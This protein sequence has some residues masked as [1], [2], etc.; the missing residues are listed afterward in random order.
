MKWTE[1]VIKTNR[2]AYDA[3]AD[4]L[5]SI[6]S[7][8]VAIQDPNDIMQK[9]SYKELTSE[10]LLTD[11]VLSMDLSEQNPAGTIDEYIDEE[12]LNEIN[13]MGKD[14][15]IIK[16]YFPESTNSVELI[17]LINEKL[18]DI[19]R[20]L[21]TGSLK[22]E[23][24]EVQ[25]EDWS[26][27]WKKY[28]KPFNITE[29][30]IIKPTWES[31]DS[32]EEK[33]IIEM[34]PGMAFGTGTHETTRLCANLLEK[35]IQKGDKV[36]DVGSGSGILTIIA[37]KLG[38]EKIL[39]LDIDKEAVKVTINNCKH[40][41]VMD[42]VTAFQGVLGDLYS[43][44]GPKF[45]KEIIEFSKNGKADIII[46]NIIASVIADLSD[47]VLQHLKP[48]GIFITSGIIKSKKDM[49]LERYRSSNFECLE[50]LE[51]G[52]WV[53]IVFKCPDSL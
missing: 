32:K 8:G 51:D 5:I 53:A 31:L 30:V 24:S 33:T 35:Y 49:I 47:K 17:Q 45:K 14:T 21:D 1:I 11:D 48:G 36:I 52:E 43:F 40:N 39:A 7:G 38:A 25:D 3:I 23:H 41:G 29:K 15:V 18:S 26:N 10:D 27:N 37:A 9:T 16:S 28:Y 6:G 13:A 22:I 19:S 2:E 12:L 50:I 34:D 46:A 42:K 44:D 4:M 20:Y